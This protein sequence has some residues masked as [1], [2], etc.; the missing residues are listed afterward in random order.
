MYFET[1]DR[2]LTPSGLHINQYP[3]EFNIISDLTCVVIE[4]QS[5][6]TKS[7][8]EHFFTTVFGFDCR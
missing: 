1:D 6:N 5:L 8:I 2:P 3:I 7:T 4:K